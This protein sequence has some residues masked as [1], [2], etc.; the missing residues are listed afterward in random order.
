MELFEE[1]KEQRKSNAPTIIWACIAILVVITVIVIAGIIYLKGTIITITIDGVKNTEIESILYRKT[2]EEGEQLYIPILKM[3][4]YLGYEGFNGDY[5]I[6]SEDKTKCY[7]TNENETAMFSLDSDILVKT[8]DNSENEYIELDESVF[9]MNGELYTSL[10][11][12]Q[13]AFNVLFYTDSDFKNINIYTMN[14]LVEFYATN[15]KIEKYSTKFVDQKA[16]LEDMLVV[17]ENGKYGVL[18]ISKSQKTYLLEAKYESVEFLPVTTDFLVKS[19]GKYGVVAKDTTTII[20]T[21]YDEIKSMDNQNGLYLVKQNGAYG[22]LDIQGN[23][24]IEPEYKQIGIDNVKQY[25]QNGVENK[26]VLLNEIIPIKNDEDL[27]AFFNIK[28]AKIT[29]FKYTGIGC[30]TTTVANSYPVVVIP[31]YK[32]IVVANDKKYDF[33]TLNGEEMIGRNIIDSVYLKTDS[34]TGENQ[35]YMMN[36]SKSV[37]IG[38]WLSNNDE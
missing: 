36:N 18:D 27:W 20:K 30:Q 17:E 11:G 5:Q 15:M 23:V 8:T 2:T 24:V 22:V 19:N 26:Y 21:V 1:K 6:K 7:V 9:E 31:S 37:D 12:I 32:L 38:K 25:A 29:D 14:Y 35:F 33:V 34:S 28:G 4:K 16:I 3:A 10:E 13:K